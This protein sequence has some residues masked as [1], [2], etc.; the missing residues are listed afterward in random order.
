MINRTISSSELGVVV[1]AARAGDFD[2]LPLLTRVMSMIAR[3]YVDPHVV[4][5]GGP[6]GYTMRRVAESHGFWRIKLDE[7]RCKIGSVF[8]FDEET[9]LNVIHHASLHEEWMVF[10]H[11]TEWSPG[12]GFK[13]HSIDEAVLFG[14]VIPWETLGWYEPNTGD[15]FV[16]IPQGEKTDVVIGELILAGVA[17]YAAKPVSWR[18]C[19]GKLGIN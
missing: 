11:G 12:P 19:N 4:I 2:A 8:P 1:L 5:Q 13:P 6:T 9:I 15:V 17:E 10:L 3:E 14:H 16:L 18:S 7:P